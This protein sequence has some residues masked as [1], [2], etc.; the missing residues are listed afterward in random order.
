MK[1]ENDSGKVVSDVL[2]Y[3]ATTIEWSFRTTVSVPFS[4]PKTEQHLLSHSH[5]TSANLS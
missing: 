2:F 3:S 5:V 4:F 1:L